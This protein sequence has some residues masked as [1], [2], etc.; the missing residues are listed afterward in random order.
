MPERPLGQGT[1]CEASAAPFECAELDPP[2]QRHR[3]CYEDLSDGSAAWLMVGSVPG[4]QVLMVPI[5]PSR[6]SGLSKVRPITV[7]SAPDFLAERY[8][9]DKEGSHA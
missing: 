7:F 2:Y 1:S 8:Y 9:N 4:E 5:S 3:E 6:Y